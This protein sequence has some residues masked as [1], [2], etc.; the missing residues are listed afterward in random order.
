[1]SWKTGDRRPKTEVAKLQELGLALISFGS[2]KITKPVRNGGFCWLLV[3][4]MIC[5]VRRIDGNNQLKLPR[6]ETK[7][8]SQHIIGIC[9]LNYF[10]KCPN[11]F[12]CGSIR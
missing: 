8:C 11:V 2:F 6:Y 4:S 1:M 10:K 12:G 7:N 3:N 5:L 9:P